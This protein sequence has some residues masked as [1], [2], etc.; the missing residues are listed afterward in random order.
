M[1][2]IKWFFTA[3]SHYLTLF[4]LKFYSKRNQVIFVCG[5][6]RSGT[7]WVSDVIAIYYNL[8]R[9]KHYLLPVLFD[10]VIHT[11]VILNS[12][13]YSNVVYV[14]RNGLDAYLSWYRS[15]RSRILSDEY[16]VG[17]E[18]F[19]GIF[20]DVSDSN[21]TSNN[22]KKLIEYD[23]T[24]REGIAKKL[25]KISRFTQDE[26]EGY[27]DYEVAVLDPHSVFNKVITKISGQCDNARLSRVLSLL[28]KEAQQVLS[29]KRRSTM[30][31]ST[32]SAHLE[33]VAQDVIDY[34]ESITSGK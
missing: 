3:S 22:V 8:P 31:N 34:Y 20:Q 24:R 13:K 7:S 10:S 14:R 16:F 29:E 2:R 26:F 12:N 32:P 25:D 33:V 27:V 30:I 23:N 1:S 21:N 17:I 5:A 18:T 9:P 6:P 11:H 28:D 4:F 19:R 15:I